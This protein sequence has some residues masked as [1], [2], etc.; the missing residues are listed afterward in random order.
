MGE[1]AM[2]VCAPSRMGP[3]RR[4]GEHY[5]ALPSLLFLLLPVY[6]TSRGFLA[7]GDIQRVQR[8]RHGQEL[9]GVCAE[10][11]SPPAAAAGALGSRAAPAPAWRPHQGDVHPKS[12]DFKSI[13][14]WPCFFP[15][16]FCFL[17]V[18]QN[19]VSFY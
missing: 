19:Q 11:C 5:Q 17:Q 13:R 6:G 16:C 2:G 15:P 7:R 18:L 10:T 9:Q 14:F 1:R 12:A 3:S 4:L 8:P